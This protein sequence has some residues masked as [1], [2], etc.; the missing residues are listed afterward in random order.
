MVWLISVA[1]VVSV[2]VSILVGGFIREGMGDE[3]S[4][5]NRE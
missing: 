3:D 5:K 4:W 1:L 2:V